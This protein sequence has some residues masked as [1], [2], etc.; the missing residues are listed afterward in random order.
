VA[1]PQTDLSI[2]DLYIGTD[3]VKGIQCSQIQAA[4]ESLVGYALFAQ[5]RKNHESVQYWTFEI[6]KNTTD[7][8]LFM[9][10]KLTK[11]I[12][13]GYYNY[14]VVLLHTT[15]VRSVLLQGQVNA[16]PTFTFAS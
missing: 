5:M 4:P 14:D 2:L 8:V 16:L 9:D 7:F 12:P 13:P 10:S 3:F 1:T 11:T 15:N 6:L